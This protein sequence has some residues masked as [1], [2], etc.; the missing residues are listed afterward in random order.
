MQAA[1]KRYFVSQTTPAG[2]SFWLVRGKDKQDY[3]IREADFE[4]EGIEHPYPATE[5]ELQALA[6]KYG[7]LEA[8]DAEYV[9]EDSPIPSQQYIPD[10]KDRS[11]MPLKTESKRP[12][13]LRFNRDGVTRKEPS[14]DD[15]EKP[16][17]GAIA[18]WVNLLYILLAIAV[19]FVCLWN[20]GPYEVAVRYV[21]SKFETSSLVDFLLWVPVIG[22]ILQGLGNFIF[23]LVGALVWGCIQLI[24]LM[25]LIM[26]NHP[27][28]V[29]SVLVQQE[30]HTRV[31]VR[32]DDP[33][34]VR[35]LKKF[36]NHLPV[37]FLVLARRL[38]GWVYVLD[39]MIV[40]M[41]YPPVREGG[42][43][44]FFFLLMTGQ[45]G[46]LDWPNIVLMFVT[47]LAVEAVVKIL[48]IV[49]HFRLYLRTATDEQQPVAA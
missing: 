14:G 18:P 37:R 38:R 45:W 21:A 42:I 10:I 33:G 29:R 49:N 34:I 1:A 8:F 48:L 19:F 2:E 11:S 12:P 46:Q 35:Y 24:E 30:A 41:V 17:Q 47:L 44:R 22:W 39:M 43:A 32:Q 36:Y 27:G 23:W 15:I 7:K 6:N 4:K 3:W 9:E 40:M 20:I 26:T 16:W 5:S 13:K 31:R 28:Y 25:P